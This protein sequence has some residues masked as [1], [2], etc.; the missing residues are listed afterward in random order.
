M[1]SPTPSP[2][3]RRT[4]S[5]NVPAQELKAALAAREELGPEME[6]MVIENF[7]QRVERAIDAQV[8]ERLA[9]R[10]VQGGAGRASR[11]TSEV[12][13]A[14]RHLANK[15]SQLTGRIAASLALGI[16]LTAISGGIGGVVGIIAVWAGIVGLNIYYTEHESSE[17][18]KLER[19]EQSRRERRSTW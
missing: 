14:R 7:L 11:V 2:T 10:G 9:E 8:D 17:A 3:P 18:E 4:S 1:S 19:L 13:Q 12:Q 16:P 6:D 5:G 15:S